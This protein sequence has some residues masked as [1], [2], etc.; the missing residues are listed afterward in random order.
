MVE[1]AQRTKAEIREAINRFF[2][3]YVFLLTPV[4]P[5]LLWPVGSL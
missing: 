4:I 1:K 5:M 3:Q 2:M